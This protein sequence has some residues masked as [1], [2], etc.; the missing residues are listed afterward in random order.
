LFVI[1]DLGFGISIAV[2]LAFSALLLCPPPARGYVEAVYSLSR[3]INESTNVV[4]VRVESVD[5]QKNTIIYSKVR[6]IKG[7]HNGAALKH[8]IGQ[9][10]YNPREWQGVMAWAE[11]GKT[12]VVFHNGSQSETCIDNYWYQCGSGDWWQMTHAEPYLLRTFAGRP[13]KL[14]G[15]VAA[16]L[17]GQEVIVPCMVDGD[18]NALQLRT[19]RTQRMRAALKLEDYNPKR[20]FVDFSG[21]SDDFRPIGGM[22]G[23]THFAAVQRMGLGASGIAPAD[24]NGDGKMDLCLFSL[25]RVSILQNTG[26]SFEEVPLPL[27]GGARAAAWADYDGSG[28][29]GLLLATPA[30]PRLFRY[31]GKQFED[32]SSLLPRE[33]YYNL[34]AAAWIDC[35][36][37]GK[38]DILLAD[39]FRG[40]R[41]YRNKGLRPEP[42]GQPKIG[43]WYFAGPFDNTDRRGFDIAYPPEHEIDLSKQYLGKM[44]EKVTWREGNFPDGQVN[45]LKLFRNECNTNCAV[46]LYRELDLGGAAEL[47]V[48]LGSDDTLTVWL[49][50]KK[51][52][53]ENVYR[54]CTPDEVKLTLRLQPGKNALLLKICQGDGDFAFYYAAKVPT[55]MG[56]PMFEDVSDAVGLGARGIAADLKGDHLAVADVNGDGRPDFLYS[57]GTG[58]LVLNTPQGFVEAKDSGISY[59]AGGVAPVFG[60]FNGGVPRDLFVPQRGVCKLFRNDGRGHFSDVTAQAGDL[61]RP[62]GQATSAVWSDFHARGRPDLFVGCLRGPNR[63]FRNN[64]DGT[65]TDATLQIG[66]MHR[67]FNTAGLAV[68]DLNNDGM[69]DLVLNNEGQ[70]SVVLLG[71]SAWRTG[72]G[73]GQVVQASF[74]HPQ[75]GSRQADSGS[76]ALAGKAAVGE[77]LFEKPADQPAA[78]SPLDQA[79]EKTAAPPP[80][81]EEKPRPE[82]EA[83]AAPPV[84]PGDSLQSEAS[85]QEKRP[86]QKLL[87]FDLKDYLPQIIAG[88]VLVLLVGGV[89]LCLVRSCRACRDREDDDD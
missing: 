11:V 85:Q 58:I 52:H 24:F 87:P 48:S 41:L 38:P 68:L 35:E 19:A 80:S 43:K 8:L 75:A 21:S 46:Y 70:E 51:I 53:E 78:S 27:E 40:L 49:N 31:N 29:P 81:G 56:P 57:A 15:Y 71:D 16:M 64:G 45:N 89:I 88:G 74:R 1:G 59:Q 2:L 25:S 37:R 17:A 36:G 23:F 34:K 73:S 12:A 42:P 82:S 61:A 18:K 10:G 67:I 28:K 47:P 55:V 76:V 4:L 20:D 79:V 26:R 63:Y 83:R 39:G 6:D 30:G 62:I 7:T 77:K 69:P 3:V 9:F 44:G 60:A 86:D 5:R 14:A 66:L 13:E 33:D 22:P 50:G 32:V 65:F 84:G 54:A 72:N